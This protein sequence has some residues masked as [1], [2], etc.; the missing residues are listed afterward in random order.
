MSTF[1]KEMLLESNGKTCKN[2]SRKLTEAFHQKA[3]LQ[4]GRPFSRLIKVLRCLRLFLIKLLDNFCNS[5]TKVNFTFMELQK[6]VLLPFSQFK[7]QRQLVP[8]SKPKSTVLYDS[9][10]SNEE[11]TKS[12]PSLDQ[13]KKKR[14]S[15][16]IPDITAAD[17]TAAPPPSAAATTKGGGGDKNIN[18]SLSS[19]S[20]LVVD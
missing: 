18:L 19:F 20:S 8:S 6:F 4:N 1:G 9:K 16:V 11:K 5:N 14:V 15:L 10:L 3:P 12:L 17:A 7:S 2:T 13:K